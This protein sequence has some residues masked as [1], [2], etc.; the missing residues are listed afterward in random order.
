VS[1]AS[2]DGG[3]YTDVTDFARHTHWL[4]GPLTLYTTLG[5]VALAGLLVV[6]WWNARRAGS[7]TMGMLAAGL[8]GIG[9]AV[10]ANELLKALFN[11]ARPCRTLPS[12]FT[13]IAC[14][15]A[16]DYAFP[17]NHSAISAAIAAAVFLVDRRLGAVAVVLALIEGFSRV[18]LGVHYP[19]DVVVGL[20]VGAAVTAAAVLAL[21]GVAERTVI[22]LERT[23]L[24]AALT[25]A[26]S[27][28]AHAAR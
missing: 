21:R 7:A 2:I 16:T 26:P 18:Y 5:V 17:S 1:A 28:G 3:L 22:A 10:V 4:N 6:A 8:V 9:C 15:G 27:G 24:R 25:S 11:E 13:V 12:S 19:H 20:L 14:P 23:P